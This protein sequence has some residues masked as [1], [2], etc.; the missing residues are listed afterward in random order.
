MIPD[1]VLAMRRRLPAIPWATPITVHLA[2]DDK[3]LYGCR[4]CILCYGLRAGDRRHLFGS[5]NEA[6]EHIAAHAAGFE[7]LADERRPRRPVAGEPG[8]I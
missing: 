2:C 1:A 3:P 5:E 4:L 6:L 7:A 8:V